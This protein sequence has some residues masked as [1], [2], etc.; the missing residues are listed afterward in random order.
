[1]NKTKA[2]I[3]LLSVFAALSFHACKPTVDM[4]DIFEVSVTNISLNYQGLLANGENAEIEIASSKSW[5]VASKPDWVELNKSDGEKGRFTIFL[6]VEKAGTEEDRTGKIV[7]QSQ[8]KSI[9]VDIE[10]VRKVEELSVSPLEI[11]VNRRGLFDDGEAPI[12]YISTNSDWL[13]SDLPVWITAEKTEGKAGEVSVALT[14][15][16]NHTGELREGSFTV[17][18]GS[19]TE[20]VVIKQDLSYSPLTQTTLITG[21]Q[22]GEITSGS[23]IFEINSIEEW[24]LTSDSWIHLTPTSGNAGKTEVV[25]SLDPTK[26]ARTGSITITDADNLTTVVSVNQEVLVPDDGKAVGFVYLQDDFLWVK[27][28]GGEDELLKAP[29]KAGDGTGFSGSAKNMHTTG[30]TGSATVSAAQAFADRN[31]EDINWDG[32]AFYFGAHYMKMG[33]TAVET[34]IK[35][36]SIPNL[37]ADKSTNVKLTFNATPSRGGS[38]GSGFDD[39]ILMVEIE[40]PGSVGIDDNSTKF[41]DDLDIQIP[42]NA[43]TDWYWIEKSVVL[44]GITSETKITIKPSSKTLGGRFNRWLIND[45]HLEKHSIVKK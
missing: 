5:V 31:Y 38:S 42:D 40:G 27:P 13:I 26:V 32:N 44:Y 30:P 22:T 39:V 37:A 45:I 7:F 25:V 14:V 28:Y 19:K 12:V 10:Q 18:S 34:G 33:R 35:L 41:K 1:M 6:T 20:I 2:I 3:M 36:T 15:E 24:T 23:A 29:T 11:A 17:T 4:I 9:S 8:G 21:D 43:S 16:K